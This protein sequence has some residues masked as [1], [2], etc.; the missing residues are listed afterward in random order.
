MPARTDECT[1][2]FH[3]CTCIYNRLLE[4]E[5]N[6]LYCSFKIQALH[7]PKE[8]TFMVILVR[9]EVDHKLIAV[10]TSVISGGRERSK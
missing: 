1:Q 10:V 7:Q 6:A 4:A 3:L 2:P 5:F 9:E 8:Q